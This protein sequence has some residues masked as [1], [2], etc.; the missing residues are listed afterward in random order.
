MRMECDFCFSVFD[1][2]EPENETGAYCP[3]CSRRL[4]SGTLSRFLAIGDR[5]RLPVS[6]PVPFGLEK[7]I[8]PNAEQ[9]PIVCPPP[10]PAPIGATRRN[11]ETPP[12]VKIVARVPTLDIAERA[13]SNEEPEIPVL[14]EIAPPAH[15][16]PRTMGHFAGPSYGP[17]RPVTSDY[18]FAAPPDGST[19][20]GDTD[21]PYVQ[22]N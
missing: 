9:P 17:R 3:F 1:L 14:E 7:T 12:Y 16:T 5:A 21:R 10:N 11:T 20:R 22:S 15:R 4:D 13:P 8:D 6:P 18:G 19:G 2:D